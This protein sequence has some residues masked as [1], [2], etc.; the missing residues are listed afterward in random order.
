MSYDHCVA[1]ADATDVIQV[2]VTVFISP[3]YMDNNVYRATVL[4]I[5]PVF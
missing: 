1:N 3:L 2:R 5:L 4:A